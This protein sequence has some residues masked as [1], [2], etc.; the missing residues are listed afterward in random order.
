MSQFIRVGKK[1]KR[2]DLS[3]TILNKSGAGF[4]LVEL[5]AVIAIIGVLAA[6]VLVRTGSVRKEGRDAAVKVALREVRNAA[7]LHY[8]NP[9][10]TYEGVCDTT[11]DTLANSGDFKRIEDYIDKNNGSTGVIG[12]RESA[13]GYAVISSLNLGSCWCVDSQGAGR[14]IALTASDCR[15][16]LTAITCP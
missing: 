6:I 10:F 3:S 12:C 11:D 8:N 1:N 16:E 9:P 14:E 7:E 5:L 2:K 15:A 13:T 4:T